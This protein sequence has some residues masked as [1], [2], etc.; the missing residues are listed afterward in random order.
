MENGNES[1]SSFST[2][3]SEKSPTPTP[4]PTN[5]ASVNNESSADVLLALRK[6]QRRHLWAFTVGKP[7]RTCLRCDLTENTY[8]MK[9]LDATYPKPL[10][11]V[12]VLGEIYAS[13]PEILASG[14][15]LIQCMV[16]NCGRHGCRSRCMRKLRD[17]LRGQK[18]VKIGTKM[19]I[20][21][22]DHRWIVELS[23]G[24]MSLLHNSDLGI[25][26]YNPIPMRSY[27]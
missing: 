16:P 7:L 13:L 11:S 2:E 19:E 6:C 10:G 3:T 18:K 14:R 9:Y 22:Q 8:C 27:L 12:S 15:L 4:R 5:S 20:S 26:S 25:E 1:G 21:I 24:R 23:C 17:V